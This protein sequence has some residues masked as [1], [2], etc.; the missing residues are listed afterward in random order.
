MIKSIQ[1]LRFYIILSI[2]ITHLY[3]LKDIS[4]IS[5]IYT[6]YLSNG[7]LGVA[8]FFILSGFVICI[9]YGNKFK[10]LD[11]NNYFS[12]MKKRII[13]I[14]PIYITSIIIMFIFTLYK[15]NFDFN[16]IIYYFKRLLLCIPLLQALIPVQEINQLFNG[17][18]W[19]LATLFILYIA[20]PFLLKLNYKFGRTLKKSII[21]IL[22]SYLIY[23]IFLYI[24]I[25]YAPNKYRIGLM[26]CSPYIRI[27]HY[28]LGM[29]LG[30]IFVAIKNRIKL[31]KKAYSLLEIF[32]IILYIL[33]FLFMPTISKKIINNDLS[34][35]I[36]YSVY[37]FLSM[38]MIFVFSFD[39][40]CISRFLS[41]S[42]N[43]YLGK[44][45]FYIYIIHLPII[46]ILYYFIAKHNLFIKPVYYFVPFI[47]FFITIS[48]SL[49][50]DKVVNKK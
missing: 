28:I 4:F 21:Y 45:S 41:R 8:F 42:K 17:A 14:Y 50:Y 25:S 19:F 29:F 38:F 35:I 40:G 23:I 26:Y 49:L 32:L 27:F 46:D 2:F 31:Q 39:E 6:K 13:K 16:A 12:F 10:N 18:A 22:I 33:C 5:D 11:F 9:G 24:I 36:S 37:I 30:N 48:L 43:L 44:I 47:C 1:S 7:A 15:N 20:T 34:I 3:F